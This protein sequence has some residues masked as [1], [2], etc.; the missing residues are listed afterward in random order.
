MLQVRL[1][2]RAEECAEIAGRITRQE[3]TE[4]MS[5]AE[6]AGLTGLNDRT[7]PRKKIYAKPRPSN[8]YRSDS[9]TKKP[10]G[11]QVKIC[12]QPACVVRLFA[13]PRASWAMR[14]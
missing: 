1:E 3:F 9:Q 12:G 13:S 4:R 11:S 10:L 6:S 5:W 2:Y 8:K 14:S 7:I